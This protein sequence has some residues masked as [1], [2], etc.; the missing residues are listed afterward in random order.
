MFILAACIAVGAAPAQEVAPTAWKN[1]APPIFSHLT[2]AD[3]LPYPVAL[4][5]AQDGKGF[6]WA[7]TPG[8][9]ARWDGYRMTVFRHDDADAASLPENIVGSILADGHGQLWLSTVSGV[10][11]R[12]DEATGGFVAYRDGEHGFGRLNGMAADGKGRIWVAGKRGLARLDV[13]AKSWVHDAGIPAGEAGSVLVD[14]SGRVWAGTVRGLMWRRGEDGPFRP[15][16]MPAEMAG[17]MVSALVEDGDGTI[18]FGTRRGRVGRATAGSANLEPGLPPSGYRV[19]TLAEPRPGLIWIGEYGGGIREF[20]RRSGAVRRFSHDPTVSATLGD[21]TVTGLL[22]DKSGL[23]WVSNLRGLDRH[24]PDNQRIM[25]IV[26][27]GPGGSPGADVRSVAATADGKLW[28]GFRAGGLALISPEAEA[29]KT[30]AP[31][32]QGTGLP[33]GV[34]Q[35]LAETPDGGFWVGLTDGLFRVNPV[36]GH[37]VPYAPFAG[38]N[39]LALRPDGGDLWAGG[40]MGLARIPLDGTSP[41]VYRFDA[42]NP[43]SLSDNSVVA[44]F[45]DRARRLWVGTWR[46]LNLLEDPTTGR[47]RRFQTDPG[48]PNSLPSDTV[49]SIAEDRRGR[50]WLATANGIGILQQKKDGEAKFVRLGSANGLP[51]GTILSVLEDQ[52]GGM[53]AGTG[54]G[55]AII[56]PDTLAVRT[57]SPA[58]GLQIRTFWAGSAARMPDGSSVLGGFGGMV[59]L[60]PTV[61]PNWSFQPPVVATGIRVGDRISS[62]PGEVVV[63]PEDGGFQADFAALDFSAPERNRYSYR[64]FGNDG[65]WTYV[66]ADHRT[67]SYSNLSPGRYRLEIRGTNSV[68]AWSGRTLALDVRVLPAWYQTSWFR[69]LAGLASLTVVAGAF[70][71]RTRYH[72]RREQELAHQ[73]AVRTAEAEKAKQVAVS[74]DQTKS[75]FLAIIGHEIRTPLNGLLGMLQLLEPGRLENDQRELLRTAKVAGETL[76][77]LVENVLEYGRAGAQSPKAALSDMELRRLATDALGLI[78][79]QAAAKGLALTLTIE[80]E[81]PLWLCCDYARLSRILLNLL[82]NAVKFTTRGSISLTMEVTPEAGRSRLRITVAD[83]GIGITPEMRHAIFEDFVQADDSVTRKFG[84]V[85]LGLAVSR[86]M[87]AE[88]GGTLTVD[89][90]V[91]AG[92][93]FRLDVAVEPGCAPTEGEASSLH[94]AGP[95]LRVLVV[96]DDEVNRQVAERFLLRLGHTP[97]TAATGEH[98]ITAVSTA[99]YDVVLMDLRMPDMDGIEAT[100]RIRLK[101]NGGQGGPRIVAMTADLTDDIRQQ[102]AAAGMESAVAKPVELERLRDALAA[103][104]PLDPPNLQ[105]KGQLALHFLGAQLDILGPPEMVRLARLFQRCS[106]QMIAT[107]DAAAE[108]PDRPLLKAE[109]HRLRSAAGPLGLVDLAARAA[110][111]EAEA[112]RG[113]QIDLRARVVELREARRSALA[114]LANLAS[115]YRGRQADCRSATLL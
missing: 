109:A 37:A 1:L 88:M 98:A 41:K 87:A 33:K 91:G 18:W 80:P 24:I 108:A 70:L 21:D 15:V 40:S 82:G 71:A 101:Q 110:Q 7:A 51:N 54:D 3:G 39:I 46:G 76:R 105:R 100:R 85:G 111:L 96:D 115:A 35:A 43:H 38:A 114:A 47:F 12:F 84:G 92:S 34:I 57:F 112:A 107:M 27:H 72:L 113:L 28:L 75:R 106:R 59:I 66:D 61:P 52:G 63:H 95:R 104:A 44:V 25:T 23:V 94:P 49:N 102:C 6:I 97:S 73:V 99:D 8:G 9:A 20:N 93:V 13:A 19:T 86:R 10:V 45:R 58:E 17:D 89:S 78:Q 77:N 14:R 81:G 32:R 36:T 65:K 56:D 5:V 55:L 50:L 31:G 103:I 22:K 4:G 64:L 16:A 26:P 2:Q 11:V 60:H 42:G 48:D 79:P 90:A 29:I 30:L 74:A 83:T 67:A 68:G 69:L 62:G 53:I